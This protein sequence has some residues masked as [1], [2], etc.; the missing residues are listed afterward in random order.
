MSQENR[1][2]LDY[3]GDDGEFLHPIA[4]YLDGTHQNPHIPEETLRDQA[5]LQPV[6]IDPLSLVPV[7][8]FIVGLLM[9]LID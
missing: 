3:V 6:V 7:L 9:L 2:I 1:S 5:E 4:E 8:A